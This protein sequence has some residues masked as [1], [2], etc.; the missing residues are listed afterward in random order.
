MWD[1]LQ[2]HEA[3]SEA[4]E[5]HFYLH[6]YKVENLLSHAADGSAKPTYLPEFRDL[7]P[8]RSLLLAWVTTCCFVRGAPVVDGTA[9]EWSKLLFGSRH[10]VPELLEW[11]CANRWLVRHPH[12]VYHPGTGRDGEK[13]GWIEQSSWYAPGLRLRNAWLQRC[14]ER[15][16]YAHWLAEQ[17]LVEPIKRIGL[18]ATAELQK[19][20]PDPSTKQSLE[21]Q[22]RAHARTEDGAPSDGADG[23]FK[24]SP[25]A[26]T[27][28]ERPTTS[29]DGADGAFKVSPQAATSVERRAQRAADQGSIAK[30]APSCRATAY[31]KEPS[32][33]Y[34]YSD[35]D[36]LLISKVA[37][38]RESARE[39]IDSYRLM[40]EAIMLFVRI[41]AQQLGVL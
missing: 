10:Y 28:V 2:C 38:D 31:P 24:V 8:L 29:C 16:L 30:S 23:A 17:K 9:L 34:Q 22:I 41:S 25:Q 3:R 12:F 18:F 33:N 35:A 21:D 4:Q 26:A 1:R 6:R 19:Q 36:I 37:P 40:P 7:S 32:A 5:L 15:G 11:L 20:N 13:V 39:M 14:A 27:S